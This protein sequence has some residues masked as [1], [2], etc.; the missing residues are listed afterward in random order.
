MAAGNPQSITDAFGVIK[1]EFSG[2]AR[3]NCVTN[4][5]QLVLFAEYAVKVNK[6][7]RSCPLF[8]KRPIP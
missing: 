8:F 7:L 6:P 4:L 5:P 3:V 2:P 1:K